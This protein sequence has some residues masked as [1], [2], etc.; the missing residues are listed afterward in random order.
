MNKEDSSKEKIKEA[1]IS[2]IKV[3]SEDYKKEKLDNLKSVP[4]R[5]VCLIVVD[6]SADPELILKKT[7]ESITTPSGPQRVLDCVKPIFF[8]L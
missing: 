6:W 1:L 8:P 3:I 2:T 7:I 4:S 5:V